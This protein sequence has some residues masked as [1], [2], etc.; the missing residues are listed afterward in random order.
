ME[1]KEHRAWEELGN[2]VQ[3]RKQRHFDALTRQLISGTEID[4]RYIDRMAGYFKGMEDLLNYPEIVNNKA[5][6]AIE[7]AELFEKE[8]HGG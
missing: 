7:K 8:Q 4:Q 1:L 6:S 3:E 2:A 5:K